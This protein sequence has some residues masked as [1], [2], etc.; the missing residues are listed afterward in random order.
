MRCRGLPA[1]FGCDKLFGAGAYG[2]GDMQRVERC[3][4]ELHADLVGMS[5]DSIGVRRPAGNRVKEFKVKFRFGG[6]PV[7]KCLR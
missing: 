2:C 7:E 5:H 3:H 6:F 4:S 1:L